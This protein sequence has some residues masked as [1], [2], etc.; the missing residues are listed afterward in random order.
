MGCL[1]SIFCHGAFGLFVFFI[2]WILY[3]F[4]T[5][6]LNGHGIVCEAECVAMRTSWLLDWEVNPFKR[7]H[8]GH[9]EFV[10]V[11]FLDHDV[12]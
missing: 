1:G 2:R 11:A 5:F 8:A 6:Y 9:D 7:E 3:P 12:R 4:D 10:E